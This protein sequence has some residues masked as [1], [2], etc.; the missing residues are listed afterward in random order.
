MS[1]FDDFLNSKLCVV[2]T[3][4]AEKATFLGMLDAAGVRW[5][6]GEKPSA[7]VETNSVARGRVH[8][9]I[10]RRAESYITAGRLYTTTEDW[11]KS[12]DF[13]VID[14]SAIEEEMFSREIPSP[15]SLLFAK[16]V[17]NEPA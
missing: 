14:F 12:R 7:L 6:S 4:E 9:I 16:E 13:T 2:C 8:F 3:T 5:V 11:A 17:S 10:P 15:L 1:L